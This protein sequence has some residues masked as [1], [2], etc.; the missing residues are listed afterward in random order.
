MRPHVNRARAMA[1]GALVILSALTTAC[2]KSYWVKTGSSLQEFDSKERVCLQEPTKRRY[3]DC[4]Q[5]AGWTQIK[6][7]TQP[8]DGYRG[9]PDRIGWAFRP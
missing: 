8:A 9:Y 6:S 3:G 5:E 7:S 1:L 2:S 4:M